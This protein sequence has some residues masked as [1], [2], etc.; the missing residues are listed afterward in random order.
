MATVMKGVTIDVT[1]HRG[2]AVRIGA[3]AADTYHR[4]VE[5]EMAGAEEEGEEGT[6]R[7]PAIAIVITMGMLL[8]VGTYH[9]RAR[10]LEVAAAAAMFLLPEMNGRADDAT[11]MKRTR[12]GGAAGAARIKSA[13]M[14]GEAQE[15][16]TAAA[17]RS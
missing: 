3:A 14:G 6:F 1:V 7:R 9:R 8:G 4:L 15:R 13:R 12:R 11:T 2:M 5:R 16:K 10:R 17:T